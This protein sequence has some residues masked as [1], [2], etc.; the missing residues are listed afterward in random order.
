MAR[1]GGRS[2]GPPAMAIIAP[3]MPCATT[4]NEPRA[5]HSPI[6]PKPEFEA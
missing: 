2:P 5:A 1:S 3:D 6:V 4:S